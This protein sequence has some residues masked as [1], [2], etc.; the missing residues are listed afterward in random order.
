ME[1]T[2]GWM[3]KLAACLSL[4]APALAD[5]NCL[6]FDGVNDYIAVPHNASLVLTDRA[7]IETWIKVASYPSG[8]NFICTRTTYYGNPGGYL[9]GMWSSRMRLLWGNTNTSYFDI[10]SASGLA[11]DA[12]THVAVTYAGD[13][14]KWYVNGIL[15]RAAAVAPRTL[16]VTSDSL[17]FGKLNQ[18]GNSYAFAG[19]LDR[20]RIWNVER[21]QAE[22]QAG[23]NSVV[24]P[25][26]PGLVAQ[27]TFNQGVAGGN[28]SGVTTLYDSSG[29]YGKAAPVDGALRNFALDGSS[30][31]WLASMAPAGVEMVDFSAAGQPGGVRLSWRTASEQNSASWI[32]QRCSSADGEFT[33]VGR[34]PATGGSSGA[35]YTFVDD[36]AEPGAAYYY[37]IG[38][39]E[40]DGDLSYYG[41]VQAA[42]LPEPGPASGSTLAAWPN[43]SRDV[44]NLRCGANSRLRVYDLTGRLVRTLGAAAGAS[45]W[46]GRDDSGLRLGPGVYFVRADGPAGSGTRKITLIR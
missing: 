6:H 27:Y 39:V 16:N 10:E 24:D 4:A 25:G 33:E 8:P 18:P 40:Q 46:D 5:H 13:T 32:V 42:A 23:M 9:F 38:E 17:L 19:N 28:N 41:P 43:P 3:L 26:V 37:W 44:V 11:L 34:L 2:I 29:A 14:V 30:S 1:R 7:T 12:W 35:A 31:N 21:T 36:A 22:I 15:D 20:F 45:A